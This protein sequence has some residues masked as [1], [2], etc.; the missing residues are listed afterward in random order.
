MGVVFSSFRSADPSYIS[1]TCRRHRVLNAAME[2]EGG[3][4]GPGPGSLAGTACSSLEEFQV[5]VEQ[6]P[7]RATVRTSTASGVL[8]GGD[9]A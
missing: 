8:T 7:P 2:S 1:R 9:S 3:S 4:A 5:L 6:Q